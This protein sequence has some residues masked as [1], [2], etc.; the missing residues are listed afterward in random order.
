MANHLTCRRW[1]ALARGVIALVMVVV[2]SIMAACESRQTA[3]E[4]LPS[5]ETVRPIARQT[6][7]K[8][9]LFGD[10]K[11]IA[12]V[13]RL[14]VARPIP[15][16]NAWSLVDEQVGSPAVRHAWHNN[17]LRIGRLASD[18]YASFIDALP[19]AIESRRSIIVSR[20]DRA[21]AFHESPPI[22]YPFRVDL[23]IPP[24]L[25]RGEV[26]RRGRMRLL[27]DWRED[28]L[29]NTAVD[30]IPHQHYQTPS[31]LPRTP[32]EVE[33]DGRIFREL[34]YHV[35]LDGSQLVVVGLY[36]PTVKRIQLKEQDR[37]QATAPPSDEGEEPLSEMVR[38]EEPGETES[39]EPA[40][41]PNDG[42][43]ESTS[44]NGK[45]D[46]PVPPDDNGRPTIPRSIGTQTMTGR[47]TG[48]PVQVLLVF[49]IKRPNAEAASPFQ[50]QAL[51]PVE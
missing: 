5:L 17:G 12:E 28:D 7:D 30:V 39:A 11:F 35:P 43:A 36:D 24:S 32:E 46:Q 10:V 37:D 8:E 16:D 25:R 44:P 3:D 48:V 26:V 15:L 9:Q 2:I 49:S 40:D 38:G 4:P 14:E 33:L 18:D 1:N 42:P 19:Q 13:V 21:Y 50:N 47:R 23:T 20:H 41:T 34:A 6:Q 27:M 29:G 22:K 45:P 51:P 31:I